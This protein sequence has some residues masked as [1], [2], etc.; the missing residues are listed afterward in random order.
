MPILSDPRW[1]IFAQNAAKGL[2]LA[3]AYAVAGYRPSG[4]NAWRLSK[5][6]RVQARITELKAV[7]AGEAGIT[8]QRVIDEVAKV[9]FAEYG[10]L[11]R[12]HEE[13]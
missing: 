10:R 2:S 8:I 9:A 5:N 11:P 1:E 3:A 12:V 4:S 6:E 7:A 13:W